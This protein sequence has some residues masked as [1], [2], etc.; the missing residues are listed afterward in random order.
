MRCILEPFQQLYQPIQKEINQSEFNFNE[1]AKP[2]DES[3]LSNLKADNIL[4]IENTPYRQ[5]F[6]FNGDYVD[7]GGS[8]FQTLFYLLYMCICGRHVYLNR[9]NHEQDD[10]ALSMSRVGPM[11]YELKLKFPQCDLSIIKPILS[12]LFASIPICTKFQKLLTTHAGTPDT[13][14]VY[15]LNDLLIENRFRQKNFFWDPT[16]KENYWH[17]FVWSYKRNRNTADFMLR[18]DIS[19]L[20][21][22]HT[23]RMARQRRL[24]KQEYCQYSQLLTYTQQNSDNRS[25]IKDNDKVVIETFSSPSNFGDMYATI[26]QANDQWVLNMNDLEWK[27]LL[28]GSSCNDFLLGPKE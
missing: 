11:V 14:Q 5:L 12:D 10:Q 13:D 23:P 27:Y 21:L 4:K 17:S 16:C 28:I 7:R 9:G 25:N 8:S 6:L 20:H 2:V 19:I 26:V 15:Y 3:L 24:F 22:G 1:A 18:N